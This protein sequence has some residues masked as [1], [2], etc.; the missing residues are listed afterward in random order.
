MNKINNN[1]RDSFKI[2]K[3]YL[4]LNFYEKTKSENKVID[5]YTYL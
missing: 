3:S 4:L 1:I 5:R 2:F